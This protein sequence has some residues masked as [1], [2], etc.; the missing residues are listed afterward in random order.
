MDH[1]M[2]K[3]IKEL[4][5]FLDTYNIKYIIRF[6]SDIDFLDTHDIKYKTEIEKGRVVAEDVYSTSVLAE[7][8]DE[9]PNAYKSMNEIIEAIGETVD[10]LDIIKPIYNFKSH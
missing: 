1:H 4:T 6:S 5:D 2:N 9:A 8:L 7:T 3:D 10:I